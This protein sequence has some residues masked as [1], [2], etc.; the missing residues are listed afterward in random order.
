MS[1]SV[2]VCVCVVNAICYFCV[3]CTRW[4]NRNII[5]YKSHN[6]WSLFAFRILFHQQTKVQTSTRSFN[7]AACLIQPIYICAYT[8]IV[9][10]VLF[11]HLAFGW[12]QIFRHRINYKQNKTL[13]GIKC[14]AFFLCC[15]V[16]S[17]IFTHHDTHN[18]LNTFL[19]K[20]VSKMPNEK[21]LK[22]KSLEFQKAWN[23]RD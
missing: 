12:R 3:L 19:L 16:N 5:G 10:S 11:W 23:R 6:L 1:M 17:S 9:C 18:S 20:S 15:L 8:A 21:L 22:E 4:F 14:Q 7:S 13:N 2:S